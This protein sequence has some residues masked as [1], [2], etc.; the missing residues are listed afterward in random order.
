MMILGFLIGVISAAMVYWL[1]MKEASHK[2]PVTCVLAIVFLT[3]TIFTLSFVGTT[4]IEGI[5]QAAA[6]A[7]LLCGIP[8][9]VLFV[10]LKRFMRN[11]GVQAANNMEVSG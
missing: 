3:W 4:I 6:V 1:F 9:M 7:A 2:K 8:G 5:P 11:P 10:L